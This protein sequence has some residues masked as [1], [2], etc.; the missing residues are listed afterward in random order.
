MDPR[1]LISLPS[2]PPVERRGRLAVLASGTGTNFERIIEAC[3]NGTLTADVV[4]LVHNRDARCAEVATRHGV[5]TEFVPHG[6]FPTRHAFDA[7]VVEKLRQW[8]PDLVVMAGWMRIA[9]NTLVS[10]YPD[11]LVNI[12]PSLLPA[13]R[14]ID[15]VEQAL[16]A[17]VTVA[18][19]TVHI[20]RLAVDDG[21]IIG[22][23]AVPVRA[24]DDS[25]TL[26]ARI[27]QAEYELYPRAIE[28]MLA[29]I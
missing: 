22:Q 5:A 10:S 3:E 28:A 20:V 12:H 19:C 18:G 24:D 27:Q 2:H 1:P 4:G 29:R 7:A 26:H 9:T 17:G 25:E 13:F 21:P 23:A 8:Q 16:A 11:R 15:A 6:D 14:G